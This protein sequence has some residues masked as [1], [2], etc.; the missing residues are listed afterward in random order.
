MTYSSARSVYD[1]IANHYLLPNKQ[2]S[3]AGGHAGH[4]ASSEQ[5]VLKQLVLQH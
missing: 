1:H 5:L 3:L 4:V 2:F